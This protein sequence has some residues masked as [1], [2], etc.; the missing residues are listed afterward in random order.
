MV[1]RAVRQVVSVELTRGDL[2]ALVDI[3]AWEQGRAHRQP[4]T[5][6]W[7]PLHDDMLAHLTKRLREVRN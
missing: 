7:S 1:E 3:L 2:S 5:Y 6:D 4:D